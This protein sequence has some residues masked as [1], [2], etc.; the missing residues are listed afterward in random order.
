MIANRDHALWRGLLVACSAVIAIWLSFPN[1]RQGDAMEAAPAPT[2]FVHAGEQLPLEKP[3]LP[4]FLQASFLQTSLQALARNGSDLSLPM[5]SRHRVRC[6]SREAARQV[7]AWA[8]AHGF[9]PEPA[10][11]FLGHGGVA[12]FDVAISHTDIPDIHH[13]QDQGERIQAALAQIPGS[14]YRTWVGEIVHHAH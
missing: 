13:I 11:T 1:H 9:E 4:D 6:E 12:F 14:H 7:S 3:A 8:T 2:P 10:E 5:R